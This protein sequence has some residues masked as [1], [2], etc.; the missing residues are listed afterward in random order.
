M[1]GQEGFI[2]KRTTDRARSLRRESP[3]PEHVL[4][5]L[6]RNQKV[7]GL[8]FRR[9]Q[10]LGPFIV[11]YVCVERMLIIEL[12]GESHVGRYQADQKRTAWLEKQGYKV[13]RFTNDEVLGDPVAVAEAIARAGGVEI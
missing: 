8:K 3:I 11:D 6:L 9:Q 2:P 12:D 5:G 1:K 10:T 4:W 7:G 13:V